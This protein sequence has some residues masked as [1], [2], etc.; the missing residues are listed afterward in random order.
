MPHFLVGKN[1]QSINFSNPNNFFGG[2][3]RKIYVC[4]E[5]K[6]RGAPHFMEHLEHVFEWNIM[7]AVHL[8]S[9]ANQSESLM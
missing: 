7:A 9:T 1:K 2:L 3:L 6:V 8:V 4:I 5:K